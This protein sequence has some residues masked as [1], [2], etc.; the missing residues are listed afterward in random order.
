MIKTIDNQIPKSFMFGG[1]KVDTVF[2]D[3]VF[4]GN[5]ELDAMSDPYT[6]TIQISNK[7]GDTT[8]SN[9]YQRVTY[10]H[11]LI[12]FMLNSLDEDELSADEQF[13]QKPI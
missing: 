11:E 3:K 4:L 1:I 12:H 2:K 5:E 10:Y 9:D 6:N 13:I 7:I 8:K